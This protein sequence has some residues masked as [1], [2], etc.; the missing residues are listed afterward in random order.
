MR[1]TASEVI[2]EL[3]M[4]VARLEK[5]A[6]N[7]YKLTPKVRKQLEKMFGQPTEESPT[8]MEFRHSNQM[9]DPNDESMSIRDELEAKGIYTDGV[10]ADDGYLT[11]NFD[12]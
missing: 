4:R 7:D 11:I 8:H 5:S 12:S 1:R 6:D 9:R 10:W 2:R 3:E